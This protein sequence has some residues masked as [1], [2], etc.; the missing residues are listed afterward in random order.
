MQI[1]VES[2]SCPLLSIIT[3]NRNNALGLRKTIKSVVTQDCTD[4]EY[5]IID[6]AS[7]DESHTVIN[8]FLS[9]KY[10]N[11]ISYWISE[12]DTGIYNAMNKGIRQARG[13][14]VYILNSGDWLEPNALSSIVEK[15]KAE[16]P[17]LLLFFLNFWSNG[18]KIQLEMRLPENLC[19]ATMCHQGLIYKK[20]LHDKYSLYDERYQFAADYDFCI[21]AFYKKN[22]N[23]SFLF[24][25][26]ANFPVGGMG[27][28][29]VSTIEFNEIQI[30]YGFI[31]PPPSR[32]RIFIKKAVKFFIP[33]GLLFLYRKIKTI[34]K[35]Y[36]NKKE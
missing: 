12:P 17:D 28:S 36:A 33:Y 25:P 2:V 26:L 24:L 19:M 14:Y 9:S 10:A 18:E 21:K 11:K 5:L 34:G 7:T 35:N 32:I 31:P 22:I 23:I 29:E 4:F 20:N 30:K 15:L 13:T 1:N 6:G 16:Q 27:G 3:I 8:E